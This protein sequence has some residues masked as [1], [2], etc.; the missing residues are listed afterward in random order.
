[1]LRGAPHGGPPAADKLVVHS[2]F[3]VP[4]GAT[5]MAEDG[6][7]IG[8]D[9]VLFTWDPY[10]NP[11]LTDVPGVIR[12]VDIVE[13]ETVREELDELTGRRQR[14]IIEDR[15]KKL[16]PHIEGIQKKGEKG[17]RGRDS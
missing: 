7:K 5:L 16:H 13:D 11:I 1:M 15:E 6:Q 4:L 14:V 8:R 10:T 12:F 2:R 9:G 3:H 17:K